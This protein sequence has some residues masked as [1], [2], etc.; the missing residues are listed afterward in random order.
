MLSAPNFDCPFSVAVDA[1]GSGAGAV[2]LQLGSDGVE[3]PV[4][5]YSK[6]FN[7]H[8]QVYSTV[9]REALALILAVQHFEVYLG[10]SS[11]PIDVFT[12]HNPLVFIDRMRNQNALC[13]GA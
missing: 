13:A 10:S 7:R 9:E 3:H 4:G 5:Y 2:L 8:Q 6:K 1:S 11:S 12:D